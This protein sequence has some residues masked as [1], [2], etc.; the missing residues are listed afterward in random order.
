MGQP[1]LFPLV[2]RKVQEMLNNYVQ[3][4]AILTDIDSY[5]VPPGL[6]NRAGVPG[7]IALGQQ[8]LTELSG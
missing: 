5:I 4:P 8:K 6:G 3:H 2:R 7:A 1:Q